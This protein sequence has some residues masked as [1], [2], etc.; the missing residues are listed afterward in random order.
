LF[1][2]ATNHFPPGELAG[3]AGLLQVGGSLSPEAILHAYARGVFPWPTSDGQLTWWSPDPRAILEP[4]A[5]HVSRRLRRTL[6][7]SRF[8]IAHNRDFRGVIHR[9]ATA[10]ERSDETWITPEIEAAYTRLHDLGHAHSVEAWR[11]DQLVG[12]VYGVALGGMFAAE[13][14]FYAER[15]ASKVALVHLAAHLRARGFVLLDIQQLS[16]HT[17]SL[18]AR[19]ISRGE[20]LRRLREALTVPARFD[21]PPLT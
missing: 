9:C 10:A 17:A 7:Q 4:A 21:G 2:G 12:G 14:M 5:V 19:N 11:R 16:P 15:D 3:P 1:V 18:G 8:E 6:R 13:S 20:Y